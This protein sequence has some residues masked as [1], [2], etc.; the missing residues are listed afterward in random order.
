FFWNTIKDSLCDIVVDLSKWSVNQNLFE[1]GRG[2]IQ[3]T[4]TT[5]SLLDGHMN[6]TV[7]WDFTSTIGGYT[8]TSTVQQNSTLINAYV[9]GVGPSGA[10]T[11][12]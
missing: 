2:R 7:N 9:E 11:A 6:N 1:N 8:N 10:G 4:G 5:G 3:T 12:N